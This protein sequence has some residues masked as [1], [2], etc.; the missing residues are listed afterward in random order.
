MMCR[1]L[2]FLL[3]VLSVPLIG[4]EELPITKLRVRQPNW[5]PTVLETFPQ[6]GVKEILYFEPMSG[7]DVPVK[8]QMFNPNGTLSL[9]ADVAVKADGTLNIHGPEVIFSDIGRIEAIHFYHD[10]ILH[11]PAKSYYPDGTLQ[12]IVDYHLGVLE[13]PYEAFH[14]DG[15]IAVRGGYKN[16]KLDGN[17]ETFF[18][19]GQRASLATYQ[20]GLLQGEASE[21][22]A[23][24]ILLSQSYFLR[25]LLNGDGK[26]LALT[27]Y[28][29][30]RFVAETQ[31]FRMGRPVGMHMKY[32][33][34]GQETF[35]VNYVRGQKQGLE[36]SLNAEGDYDQGVAVGDHT[37]K[38]SNGK[39][40][41]FARYDKQGKLLQPIV[42]Y[43]DNGFKRLEYVEVDGLLQGIWKEFYPNGKIRRQYQ[44]CN[45]DFDG[46]QEEFT[47]SGAP[48]LRVR[49]QNGQKE[50]LYQ[51]WN[52][53]QVLLV[54]I[55][56]ADGQK[57]GPYRKWHPNGQLKAERRYVKGQKEDAET[58]W[59]Q[60]GVVIHHA[61]YRKG[62]PEGTV[63]GWY[64]SGK[65]KSRSFYENGKLQGE[66]LAWFE[67]GALQTT[68]HFKDGKPVGQQREYYPLEDGQTQHQL[69]KDLVYVDGLLQGEQKAFFAN[70]KKKTVM[71]Y[72]DNVLHGLKEV[73]DGAGELVEQATYDNG[74]LN[75]RY[76]IRKNDGRAYVYNY[77]Y[78]ILDGIHQ[79][80][81]PPH[82]FFGV[83]KSLEGQ[84]ENGLFEGQ[85]NEFNEA[86]TKVASTLYHK[87]LKE[88]L[89]LL[90]ATDGKLKVSAEFKND[91][92]HGTALEYHPNGTIARQVV[93]ADNLKQS[94]EKGFFENGRPSS[95]FIYKEG[96]LN[97][98]CCEWNAKGVL[99]FEG[100]YVDGKKHGKFNKYDADGKPLV[101]QTFENN[102]LI[103]K[104]RITE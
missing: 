93:F 34:Q 78:N 77:K 72:K 91:N 103:D 74:Q 25:G 20:G 17:H 70:G 15:S 90:Y 9:E 1:R 10:G 62:A 97:G 12:S 8:R 67:D 54:E 99:I 95:L 32:D 104:K 61:T 16:G 45:G 39:I 43:D 53:D 46:L 50:G 36:K 65:P 44:Y 24:G 83:V 37:R 35:H 68:R 11:G 96:K 87:G 59:D 5:T 47:E 89:T 31:D 63:E 80:Y 4:S 98:R 52:D 49:Y 2:F 85:V 55:G 26:H 27:K 60:S 101:L 66:Y 64:A 102:R 69:A 81:H 84:Y 57:E 28:H 76:Y 48:S 40:A 94:E 7:Q 19:G 82:K 14:A 3:V 75:G 79:I 38:H 13:G 22:N 100:E 92:Q 58:L 33:A 73:W 71:H 42:E 88:G 86:G 6:G 23:E 18:S 41:Y 29:P 51:E 56:F 30:N 21:W